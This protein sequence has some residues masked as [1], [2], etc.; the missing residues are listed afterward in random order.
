MSKLFVVGDSFSFPFNGGKQLWPLSVARTLEETY[1]K[2]IEIVNKSLIGASQDYIWKT[3]G[4]ILPEVTP[5]DFLIVILTSSDRFW[6]FEDRPEYSNLMSIENISQSTNDIDLQ[7]ILI[8]FISRIWRPSLAKQLQDHRLG[9]LSYQV[10]KNKLRRPM[11]IKGFEYVIDNE[12]KFPDLN[13]SK[14]SLSKIQLEEFEKFNG[15]FGSVDLLIDKYWNHIDCRY[16][17]M[18]ISNHLVLGKMVAE[19]LLLDIPIDLGSNQFHK[20]IIT[21]A[22]YKDKDFATKELNLKYF[23]E[24]LSNSIRQKLGAKSF[25]LLF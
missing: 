5:D 9:Y 18:C 19:G 13:F 10:L 22:N 16:N 4:D 15:I 14:H 2:K 12:D 7:K 6:Y 3:L 23:N 25:K 21:T 17:H 8:G 11:I 20:S 24:M 1:N